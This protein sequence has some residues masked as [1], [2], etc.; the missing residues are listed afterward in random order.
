MR[1]DSSFPRGIAVDQS[2]G[3]VYVVDHGKS[4][5]PEVRYK[6]QRAPPAHY[7]IG[8]EARKPVTRAARWRRRP[9]NSGLHGESPSME[10][11]ECMSATPET[12]ESRSSIATAISSHNGVDLGTVKGNSIFPTGIGVDA[13]EVCSSSTAAIPDEQFM[14]AEEGG[15]R[16]QEVA[17]AAAELEK[18]EKTGIR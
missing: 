8:G 10:S 2:D 12:I 6:H 14:P 3:S 13:E 11:G 16:L 15:E 7:E 4:P 5:H 17:E 9:A 1:M 18:V